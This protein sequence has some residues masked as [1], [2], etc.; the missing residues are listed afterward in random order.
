MGFGFETDI[1]R[2]EFSELLSAVIAATGVDLSNYAKPSLLRRIVRFAEIKG[3]SE[4]AELIYRVR[5]ESGFAA[6]FINEI[7]VSVTEMFRNPGFWVAL[8]EKVLPVL[9]EKRVISVW[10]AGC[11]MGEEAY[12]MAIMLEE[13][14]LLEKSRIY[15]TD[16]NIQALETGRSGTYSLK[17]QEVNSTNYIQAG[18]RAALADNY[19]VSGNKVR[20]SEALR[21]RIEFKRHDLSSENPFGIFDLVICRNVFI[22]FNL[23]L[24]EKVLD[25]FVQ[26]M[27]KGS[28]LGVGSK[29][30]IRWCRGARYF[31][32]TDLEENLF[33]KKY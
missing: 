23:D 27:E 3:I 7:T 28:F 31:E 19:R 16:I 4:I 14:G 21:S 33:Q 25:L 29:E 12:S 5:Y 9:A 32:I 11:S 20:F 22:Y 2:Y 10:H 17:N 24:Q 26:S 6:L 30:S 1:D 8:K 13:A 15:A 18:G